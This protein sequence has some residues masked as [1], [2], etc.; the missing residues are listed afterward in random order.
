MGG[1]G[2]GGEESSGEGGDR[3]GKGQHTHHIRN[4][5]PGESVSVGVRVGCEGVR[6]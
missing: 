5:A 2:R 4:N 6:V 3:G 1:E